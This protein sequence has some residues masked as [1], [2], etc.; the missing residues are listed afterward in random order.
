MMT[1]TGQ[2]DRALAHSHVAHRLKLSSDKFVENLVTKCSDISRQIR[3]QPHPMWQIGKGKFSSIRS[4]SRKT[5]SQHNCRRRICTF[6]QIALH[7]AH[8]GPSQVRG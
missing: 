5:R 6:V 1:D 3:S 7:P 4:Q 2:V 8:H